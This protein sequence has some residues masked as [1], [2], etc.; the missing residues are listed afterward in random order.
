MGN[1]MFRVLRPFI[2]VMCLTSAALG[3]Q[4]K[5]S[6]DR[7]PNL[8]GW[9][10]FD[11]GSGGTAAEA[12]WYD[13]KG[14]LLG[15]TS[16]DLNSVP[17]KVG[18]ALKLSGDDTVEM[19]GYKGL[20]G[21]GPRTVTA[22]IKTTER[23][24]S[25]VVWGTSESGKQFR[26]GHIRGRIGL[27]PFG[28]YLYVKQYTNDDK[29][30]HVAVVVGESDLP[31]LHDD[32]VLYLDGK[33]AEIDDI[34]LLDLLPIET[35]DEEDVRIGGGYAGSIDDLRIYDRALS[36]EEVGRIYEGKSDQPKA[37]S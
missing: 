12:S 36:V 11:D 34:G 27:T 35:G 4:E 21:A 19:T 1:K 22:W 26:F 31:N 7:D 14:T 23:R 32:V 8:A 18:W 9:W 15:E 33:V 16:F 5:A 29:W 37:D 10:K 17:G 3:G 13:R 25:I 30:H 20:T 2:V 28:G 6:L 24:G